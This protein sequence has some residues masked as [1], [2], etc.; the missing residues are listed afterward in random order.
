MKK[1]FLLLTAVITGSRL[2]SQD[3]ATVKQLGEVVITANKFAQ[4][5]NST[6]KIVTVIDQQMLRNFPGSSLAEVLNTQAGFFINGANNAPGSNLD[7]Y[8]RGAGNG[9]LLVIIDGIPVYDP[10]FS[11]NAFDLN[12]IPLDQVERIEILKGGQSTLWGS[13]AVAGVIQIFMKKYSLKKVAVNGS[14]AYGTYNTFRGNAGLSGKIKE[15]GYSVQYSYNKSRGLSA[16]Y[17]STGKGNFDRDGFEQN[18]LL[19]T[20]NYALTRK[21]Q[22]RAFGSFSAYHNDLD[23]GAFT[24]DKDFTAKNSNRLGGLTLQYNDNDFTWNIQASLQQ[25]KRSF[26]D[27][28]TID[29]GI[30]SDFSSGKYTGRTST[31][32]TFGNS[33]LG[34]HLQ[35]VGGIQYLRQ[36]TD[37]SYL[38]I[39][40]W[41]LYKTAL[42][43]DSAC[44]RE[45]SAYASLL[46]HD[47]GGFNMELGGRYNN[48]SMYG[49]NAT[50]T[51]NPSFNVDDNTRLFFN[52]SS[53]YKVPS[54]YQLYSEYGNKSLKPEQS[55]TYELGIQSQSS[56]KAVFL[57]IAGFKRDTRNLIV[58]YTDA[59]YNSYYINRDKQNDYGFEIESSIQLAGWGKW[60]NNISF[61]DGKGKQG[62]LSVSNLYRRPKFVF[63][64]AL[65]LFPCRGLTLVPSFRYTGE[66]LKG[67]YDAGPEM[68]PSYYIIDFVAR[69]QVCKTA[70]VFADLHNV[71]GQ[72]YFDVVG[73]NSKRFNMMAGVSINF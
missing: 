15:L 5:Q 46:L 16:A 63:S 34:R 43:K 64:S 47:A 44:I 8:F 17:D 51:I 11:T 28:S 53:A 13:D 42:G 54:L 68:Q 9:N 7:V 41:G 60:H 38:S 30:Y 14:A 35:W 59:S 57:R 6:G 61:V 69:Y 31:V 12:N 23:A 50:Y 33:K 19:A 55:T 45:V 65:E 66:R 4:K 58:F 10:S 56:N 73:Y 25:V 52:I 29:R 37:Q 3:S 27:D 71:T 18:A 48:H 21:L 20:L 70:S 40:N 39:S 2:W 49:N 24:D 22:A 72:Q 1:C 26:V 36:N 62:N 32:E 67:P